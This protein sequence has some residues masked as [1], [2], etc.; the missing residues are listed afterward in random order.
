MALP[1]TYL[2]LEKSGPEKPRPLKTSNIMPSIERYSVF[3]PHGNAYNK[4]RPIATH[5]SWSVSL[6]VC[7]CLLVELTTSAIWVGD[8][9]GPK[10]P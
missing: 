10:K 8:L 3:R 5:V 7:V 4:M 9:G 6:S 2:Q 1:V